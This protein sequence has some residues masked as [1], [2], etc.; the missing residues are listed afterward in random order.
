MLG[1]AAG[2]EG[3]RGGYSDEAVEQE[4][5]GGGEEGEE[6][7]EDGRAAGREQRLQEVEPFLV[8]KAQ[9]QHQHRAVAEPPA[10]GALIV[11][12]G[13][14]QTDTKNSPTYTQTHGNHQT[15][16]ETKK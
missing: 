3:E 12:H 13:A 4:E 6:E 7:G 9:P 8:P 14:Q 10:L 15:R 11:L 1:W 16:Q 2:T 5:R